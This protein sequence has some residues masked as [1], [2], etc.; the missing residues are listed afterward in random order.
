MALPAITYST[1]D[2]SHQYGL[3]QLFWFG[4]SNC[5]ETN[6]PQFACEKDQWMSKEGWEEHIRSFV[7]AARASDGELLAKEVL[8]IHVPDWT[9]NGV[10]SDI[11][12]VTNR[13]TDHS[14]LWHS[15]DKLDDRYD[16][17]F[18]DPV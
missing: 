10:L 11:K 8:W 6:E 5:K 14:T 2:V 13:V 18:L 17:I 16:K 15:L 3:R 7:T 4:S 12:N 9:R 1:F